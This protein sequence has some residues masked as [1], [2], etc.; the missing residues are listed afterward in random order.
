MKQTWISYNQRDNNSI[1]FMKG[2]F[3]RDTQEVL[4]DVNCNHFC[5]NN[6]TAPDSTSSRFNKMNFYLQN[7]T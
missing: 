2:I 6:L 4:I 5:K 1:K 3:N 7:G